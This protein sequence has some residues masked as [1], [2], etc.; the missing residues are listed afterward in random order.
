MT[1]L[2][3]ALLVGNLAQAFGLVLIFKAHM[4]D[5]ERVYRINREVLDAIEARQIQSRYRLE[6]QNRAWCGQAEET[7]SRNR[8]LER[9]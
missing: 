1:W 8:P 3:W 4:R 5:C 9:P 2:T 6:H 7:G